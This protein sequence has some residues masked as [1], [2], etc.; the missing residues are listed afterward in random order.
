MTA[1]RKQARGRQ[2]Q[3]RMPGC[4]HDP[5]T[6]VLAHY[7]L[8]GLSGTGIK[9]PDLVGAWACSSC[10]DAIDG[11]TGGDRAEARLAHAEG[12]MRTIYQLL[13]NGMEVRP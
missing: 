9:P 4:N 13:K 1:L 3:V 6:T 10:H 2:C 11:R 8:S 5:E 7:R 12:V